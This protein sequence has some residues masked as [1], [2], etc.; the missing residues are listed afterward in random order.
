M[1]KH[2]AATAP[3]AGGVRPGARCRIA[4]AQ[5]LR[6]GMVTPQAAEVLELRQDRAAL[7][8]VEQEVA[9]LQARRRA[10]GGRERS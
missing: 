8:Q 1:R 10:R 4:H 3:V 6:Q 7:A 2:H 5:L 9:R